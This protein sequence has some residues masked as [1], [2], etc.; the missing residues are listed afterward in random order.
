MLILA[1]IF[2][3]ILIV[4]LYAGLW[5]ILSGFLGGMVLLGLTALERNEATEE[6]VQEESLDR[7]LE[8]VRES[9]RLVDAISAEIESIQKIGS[10]REP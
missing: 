5:T 8:E 7:L 1:N 4:L 9:S 10:S 3:A 2:G 6:E